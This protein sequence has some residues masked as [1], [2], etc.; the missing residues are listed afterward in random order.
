MK[1]I[2]REIRRAHGFGQIGAALEAVVF[3]VLCEADRVRREKVIEDDPTWGSFRLIAGASFEEED[4]EPVLVVPGA[5]GGDI[6]FR[7]RASGDSLD[8]TDSGHVRV[9]VAMS[10]CVR[11]KWLT[12]EQAGG[13]LRIRLGERAQKVRE[14]KEAAPARA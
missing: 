8:S 9:R 4:G 6:R 5:I 7:G 11:N 12:A 2:K 14:G 1:R 3:V 13:E 10:A